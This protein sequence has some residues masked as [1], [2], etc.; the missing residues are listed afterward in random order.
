MLIISISFFRASNS[1]HTWFLCRRHRALKPRFEKVLSAFLHIVVQNFGNNKC[2]PSQFHSSELL[3]PTR[4]GLC[5]EG[6]EHWNQV[7]R[8]FVSISSHRCPKFRQEEIF[9]IP[10]SF[11][12][13]S[14]S[15]QKWFLCRRHRALKPRFEKV[16]SAFLHIVVQNFGNNKC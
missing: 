11:F 6:I 2:W 10:N 5:A 3:I 12:Q 1:G 13:A 7:L 4:S 16:L 8:R 9:T 15:G 14:N